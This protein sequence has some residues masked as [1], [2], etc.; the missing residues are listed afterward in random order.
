[1]IIGLFV[2]TPQTLLSAERQFAF[3]HDPSE[4]LISA[5]D[6]FIKSYNNAVKKNVLRQR[7]TV[8]TEDFYIEYTITIPNPITKPQPGTLGWEKDITVMRLNLGVT[9][10]LPL[11]HDQ[12]KPITVGPKAEKTALRY[13]FERIASLLEDDRMHRDTIVQSSLPEDYLPSRTRNMKPDDPRYDKDIYNA[14]VP[15]SY[16]FYE[17]RTY[18]YVMGANVFISISCE[19]PGNK[20]ARPNTKALAEAIL[21]RM[22]GTESRGAIE[23]YPYSGLSPSDRG[24]MPASE[25][26]PAKI[27]YK[28]GTPNSEVTFSL[29]DGAKGELRSGKIS[30]KL[31]T[32]T[33]DAAGNAE[34][35]YYYT[36]QNKTLTAPLKDDIRVTTD[37]E[38]KTAQIHIGL[39]LAFEKIKS[40]LGQTYE[41]NTYAFTLSVKSTFH[42]DLNIAAYL[43][44]AEQAKVWGNKK[45][46]IKL[47]SEW[48]NRPTDSEHD[49]YYKGTANITASQEKDSI[50]TANHTPWFT[51]PGAKF[52]YPAVVMKTPG[53]HAYRVNGQIAVLNRGDGNLIAYLDEKMAKSDTLLILSKEDPERWYQSLACSLNATSSTQWFMLEAVK[54]IPVYGE[55]VDQLTA[56]TSLVCGLL[57]EDYEKSIIDLASWLGGKYIDNLMEPEVFNKLTLK[58]QDAVIIAKTSTFGTDMYKKK[59]E[60]DDIKNK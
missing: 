18:Y 33:S 31:I 52:F 24:L 2:L 25:L 10:N 14:R 45:L 54:M 20:V 37:G 9:K 34:T 38:T 23:V 12:G 47:F 28:N 6:T 44:N 26:L 21:R 35:Y 59:G 17:T 5:A 13:A 3:Y 49:E 7:K 36:S 60:I 1:M 16:F 51:P 48:V 43:F 46:G 32:V 56:V 22:S 50:L 15:G 53:R 19:T 57:K 39:G 55:A 8:Q 4:V 29:Q 11:A 40:V 41:N 27:L 42:P 30:G 58:Q